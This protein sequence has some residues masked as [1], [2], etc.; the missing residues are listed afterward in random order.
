MKY[1]MGHLGLVSVLSVHVACGSS[2][3]SGVTPSD[4]EVA[5]SV[6]SG[7]LN[8]TSGSAMAFNPPAGR[9]RKSVVREALEVLDPIGTAWGATWSCTGGT[10]SPPYAGPTVAPYSYTPR[11]CSVTWSNNRTASSSWSGA[12]TLNYGPTCDS[13]HAF[14]GD[15]MASCEVTRT[16][17]A[18]G[19]TRTVQGPDGNSYAITHDTNGAGTGWDSSVTPVP[20][21]VGLQL[22]GTSLAINGSHLTGTVTIDDTLLTIWDHTVS[23][24]AGG[25]AIAGTGTGRVVTG[26]VT[27]QHNLAKVTS[28]VTF[29]AVGY[30]K[31][32]CCFPTSGNVTSTT[33]SASGAGDTETLSF[34]GLCGEATLIRRGVASALTLLHCL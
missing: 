19:N 14:I 5:V 30:G 24:G 29:N 17:G 23:T 8:N 6:V 3:P 16:T 32:D 27:V 34:T 22:T 1:G 31:A 33:A 25:V 2:T 13:T 12:F 10:L 11:S 21:N 28:T 20:T 18:G 26:A 15:Q 4:S 9:L 7:G